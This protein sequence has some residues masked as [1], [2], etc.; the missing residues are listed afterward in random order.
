MFLLH[1]V[2]LIAKAPHLMTFPTLELPLTE[3]NTFEHG[4]NENPVS[5]SKY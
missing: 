2:S 3:R 5:W 1:D 4:E